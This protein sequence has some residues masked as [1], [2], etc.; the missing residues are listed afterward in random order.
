MLSTARSMTKFNK[1]ELFRQLRR[2]HFGSEQKQL[3]SF[4]TNWEQVSACSRAVRIGNTV[5]VS[6][7]CA[8]GDTPTEQVLM[9]SQRP[10][11]IAFD[12]QII[13]QSQLCVLMV[14]SMP[15]SRR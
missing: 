8:P 9:I 12:I 6:G 3:V 11:I 15:L 13:D 5:H 4:G 2:R 14:R 7:T 1:N 10:I